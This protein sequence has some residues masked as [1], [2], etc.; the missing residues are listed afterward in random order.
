[1]K[2]CYVL[3]FSAADLPPP[4]YSPHPHPLTGLRDFYPTN[5]FVCATSLSKNF[6]Q[7]AAC[8][9]SFLSGGLC[10]FPSVAPVADAVH[11]LSEGGPLL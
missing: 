3:S 4:P 9:V 11:E 7:A 5:D 2:E 10:Q 6:L 1:M 8:G